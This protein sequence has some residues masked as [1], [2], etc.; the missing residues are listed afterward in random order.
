M[1]INDLFE[2][3]DPLVVAIPG[4]FHPFHPGHLS[5]LKS[6]QQAFPGAKVVYSATNST[7]ERPF[8]FKAKQELATIAGVPEGSFV[9][10]ANPF[11]TQEIANKFDR[12]CRVVF[13]RGEKDSADT[14]AGIEVKYLP[15]VPFQA[16]SAQISSGTELRKTWPTANQQQREQIARDLYPRN[17]GRA[18]AILNECLDG[19]LNEAGELSSVYITKARDSGTPEQDYDIAPAGGFG[20]WTEPTLVSSLMRDL[21]TISGKVKTK[22][23]TDAEYLLYQ[24]YSTVKAK[25]Q[26][27]ARFEEFLAKNGRRAVKTGRTIELPNR[28]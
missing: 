23:A 9:E 3:A 1:F 5:L 14:P 15:I 25:L 4:G 6:A 8:P 21:E 17:P 19:T 10:V 27:L 12:P 18:M 26:A 7:S 2:T 16:G 20:T 24:K 11:S 22:N 13:A 28:V